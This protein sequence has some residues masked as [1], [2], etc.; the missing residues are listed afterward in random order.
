[1]LLLLLPLSSSFL[2]NSLVTFLIDYSLQLQA[3]GTAQNALWQSQL[4]ATTVNNSSSAPPTSMTTTPAGSILGAGGP[5]P[6]SRPLG[7][8]V[9]HNANP[10]LNG[11]APSDLQALQV[12]LQQQQHHLQQQLQNFLLFQQPNNLQ[13]SAVLL[14]TQI[15]QAVAQATNQLRLLQSKQAMLHH[16]TTSTPKRKPSIDTKDV[17]VDHQSDLKVHHQNVPK[18]SPLPPSCSSP[19]Q[20]SLPTS[21]QIRTSVAAPPMNIMN[22]FAMFNPN[23][24]TPPPARSPPVFP[25]PG[26]PRLDL[27][28]DENVD[29]EELEQFAKEFKQRR[30]KLGKQD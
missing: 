12:A 27:P 15:Q 26:V 23:N 24:A 7:G 30:I 18:F 3:L 1:M 16:D 8:G 2:S 29:L 14:Q 11:F 20:T 9:P 25:P 22:P 5:A 4:V 10:T 19:P 13:T 21:D 17:L 28:A 6:L